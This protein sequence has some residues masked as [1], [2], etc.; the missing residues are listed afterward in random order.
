MPEA[1]TPDKYA[2]SNN[3]STQK[4]AHDI[5]GILAARWGVILPCLGLHGAIALCAQSCYLI[6]STR[7]YANRLNTEIRRPK[8]PGCPT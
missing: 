2:Q 8:L 3:M 7:M 5:V 1:L 4:P 6:Y